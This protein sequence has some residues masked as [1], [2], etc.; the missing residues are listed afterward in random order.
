[1]SITKR[2]I[3]LARSN[4]NS[5]L[6]RVAGEEHDGR[7]VDDLSDQELEAEL[8]R[9]RLEREREQGEQAARQAADDRERERRRER[10][11]GTRENKIAQY[12]AQLEVPYGSN[13]DTVKQAYRRLMRKY[14]PDLHSG[15]PEKQKV[16]TELAQALSRAYNELEV[17][18]KGNRGP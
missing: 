13:L 11:A 4:L 2:L 18:L 9:R 5:L 10:V 1:M 16:A 15:D 14:H 7:A 12:Y 6:D 3:D 8:E 17:A